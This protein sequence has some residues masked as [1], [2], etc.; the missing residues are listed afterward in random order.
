MKFSFDLKEEDVINKILSF[1]IVADDEKTC[2][3]KLPVLLQVSK[4]GFFLKVLQN[5]DFNVGGLKFTLPI[6]II[7]VLS[8]LLSGFIFWLIFKFLF[9]L[10]TALVISIP[11]AFIS[12]GI[13]L[14]FI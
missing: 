10:Q 14:Y 11:L 3:L 6:S 9:K 13:L 4:G 1:N 12:G 8:I 7:I 2:L 5:K